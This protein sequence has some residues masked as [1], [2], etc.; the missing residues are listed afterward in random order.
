MQSLFHRGLNNFKFDLPNSLIIKKPI[1]IPMAFKPKSIKDAVRPGTNDC[2]NSV[3]M[4]NKTKPDRIKRF[5]SNLFPFQ[6]KVFSQSNDS[7]ANAGI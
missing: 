2:R 1:K 5:E 3:E 7:N 4:A 6:L